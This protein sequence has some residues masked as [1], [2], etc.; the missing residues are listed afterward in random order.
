MTSAAI[1]EIGSLLVTTPGH[2]NG[3]PCLRGTGITVHNVAL[4]HMEGMSVEEICAQNPHLDPALFHAAVAYY[5]ANRVRVEA[6]L[7]DDSRRGEALRKQHPD[8]LGPYPP[9]TSG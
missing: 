6:E 9:R 2:R 7:E 1:V 5:L 4:R 3:W 8:G